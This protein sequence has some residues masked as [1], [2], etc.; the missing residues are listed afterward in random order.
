MRGFS[1]SVALAAAAFALLPPAVQAQVINYGD[2]YT[3]NSGAEFKRYTSDGSFVSSHS[4]LQ[5][6]GSGVRGMAYGGD[7]LMYVTVSNGLSG[8]NVVALDAAGSVQRAFSGPDY[9]TGN[10]SYGK[11]AFAN[12]GQFFVAGQNNLRRFTLGDSSGT[13][14]YSANQ[15]FDATALPSGNLL[16]LSA[17]LLQ[18]ITTDG[19]IVRTI[20][21][22]ISLGDARGVAYNP[23]TDDIYVTMLGYTG[24]S[25]RV[26]RLDGQTG[27]VEKNV[28][29]WYADDLT[30]TTDNRLLVGSRTQN[31]GV[32]DL[33]LNQIGTLA[34]GAQIF[35]S[36]AVPV[37]EPGAL[38]FGSLAVA[39]ALGR[40]RIARG[41]AAA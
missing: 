21:T 1:V 24:Q 40:R 16:V 6:Y 14:V 11:I 22:G 30:L 17:Y 4:I 2:I 3:S 31:P 8:Y 35:V 36:Q 18:E 39:L 32:F 20:P 28:F 34:G 33:D 7:G 27:A 26:L 41:S 5:A 10:I 13:V 9:V 29:F 19:T 23:A 38:V 12:N 37:P 25:F 15:V